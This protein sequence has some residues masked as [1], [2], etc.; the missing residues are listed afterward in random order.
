MKELLDYIKAN[1]GKLNYAHS[2]VGGLPHLTA[3]LFIA[4]TGA[5]IVGVPYRS[6]GRGRNGGVGP[7]RPNDVRG[8]QHPPA[9]D[10]RG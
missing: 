9:A 4:R 6:G 2:G 3:E 7:K 1:P 8:D 10:Q 5:N